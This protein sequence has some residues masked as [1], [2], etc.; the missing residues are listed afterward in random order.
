MSDVKI[1]VAISADVFTNFAGIQ[2]NQQNKVINFINKFRNNPKS[3][4]INYEKIIGAYDQNLRSVR[5][6]ENYRGIILKPKDN[7]V[8]LLL[9]IDKHDDAYK[10]AMRKRAVVN[11]QT[12]SIQVYDVEDKTIEISNQNSNTENIDCD[13]NVAVISKAKLFEEIDDEILLKI[14]VPENS[15]NMVREIFSIEDLANNKNL[16][17]EDA[18]AALYFLAEGTSVEEIMDAFANNESSKIDTND[19]AGALDNLT[20]KQKYFAVDEENGQ[21]EL[22]KI[23]D[24]PLEKWRVFL[25]PSQRK[26]VEKN[27]NG[28]VRVLGGAGTGKTVVAMHRA[29]WLAENIYTK[30]EEKILFTTFTRN[31]S[32]DIKSNLRKICTPELMKRIDVVNIDSWVND[33]LR[34]NN[35][36]YKIIYGK[37]LN[38]LWKMAFTVMNDEIDVNEEFYKDEWEQVIIPNSITTKKEYLKVSRIGRGVRLDR[39]ARSLVWE[40][41][42]EFINLMNEK[43]VR[44]NSTA[45]ME[46]RVILEKYGSILPYKAVIVDE[47]QDLGP[48][49]FKLIRAIAGKEHANDIFI[50]GDTHQRIYSNNKVI[51]SKCGINI[52]GRSSKLKINYRTTEE[53]RNWAFNIL[54]GISFDDMDE[55]QDDSKGYKSLVHGPKPKISSFKNINE[56]IEYLVREIKSLVNNGVELNDI[57]LVSRIDKQIETY[58]DLLRDYGIKSHKIKRKEAENRRIDGVRVATMHRVKGLEFDYVFL[59]GINDNMIP[60]KKIVASDSD[61]ISMRD[62]IT[63]ER[64][65]LYVAATRAKK[66]VF[67][68]SYGMP[69]K[70]LI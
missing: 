34:A 67:V 60:Y 68:S 44:D 24:A 10:W 25:H 9:W 52:K 16:L 45:M 4:G 42:E 50:V 39:K 30:K 7:N 21:E 37:E 23:L 5:I 62:K 48:Q 65:L 35:Y 63:N 3:P 13:S 18:Y 53:T 1:R 66:A 31:L 40:V 69:S 32:E 22:K 46:A 29:K 28:P 12:G 8:Y 64:S 43:R 47:A 2:R 58:R 27:V 20:T 15:L 26:I 61:K 57:C 56:E 51:L 14:G 41:F 6:D 38:D 59:V 19:F 36:N 54:N 55:G 70:F 49:T 17:P 33:F 11:A